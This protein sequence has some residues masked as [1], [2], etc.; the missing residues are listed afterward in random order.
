MAKGT[1]RYKDYNYKGSNSGFDLEDLANGAY[2]AEK[3]KYYDSAVE[4][5]RAFYKMAPE[6]PEEFQD[7]SESVDKFKNSV[8]ETHNRLKSV[9]FSLK[10][11]KY[12]E[13][14]FFK[15]YRLLTLLQRMLTLLT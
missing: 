10:C 15:F 2:F 13:S 12:Q 5:L 7:L 9:L 14:S 4:F 8:I 11:N 6:K 1:I 3:M